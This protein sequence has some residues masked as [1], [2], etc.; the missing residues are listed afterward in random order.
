MADTF[1]HTLACNPHKKPSPK[2]FNESQNHLQMEVAVPAPAALEEVVFTEQISSTAAESEIE[3]PVVLSP[4]AA[5]ALRSKLG[6]QS[7]ADDVDAD[8][9]ADAD[10]DAESETSS[11]TGLKPVSV[12]ILNNT[13]NIGKPSS[14]K[15]K[16][17]K[18]PKMDARPL[19]AEG[20][21]NVAP[22]PTTGLKRPAGEFL[23]AV[24]CAREIMYLFLILCLQV[25]A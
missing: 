8:A 10:A 1:L 21:E 5:A 4:E 23:F 2:I 14:S 19:A 7:M 22:K 9:N 17:M 12:N 25:S 6:L 3:A 24:L 18:A 20:S 11:S 15:V 13:L 16:K